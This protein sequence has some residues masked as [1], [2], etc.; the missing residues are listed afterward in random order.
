MTFQAPLWLFALLP[1]LCAAILAGFRPPA[2]P[3]DGRAP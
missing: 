2:A 3:G 1:L